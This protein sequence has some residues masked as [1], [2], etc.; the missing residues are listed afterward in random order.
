MNACS[1]TVSSRKLPA[2]SARKDPIRATSPPAEKAFPVPVKT[3]Q[4]APGSTQMDDAAP[5]SSFPISKSYTFIRSGRFI[6]I[7]ATPPCFS[8]I[9]VL[10]G[11]PSLSMGIAVA[12]SMP[13]RQCGS[14][15]DHPPRHAVDRIVKLRQFLDRGRNPGIPGPGCG[16]HHAASGDGGDK[17]GPDDLPLTD[18]RGRFPSCEKIMSQGVVVEAFGRRKLDQGRSD[19]DVGTGRSFGEGDPRKDLLPVQ[20]ERHGRSFE[21]IR[22]CVDEFPPGMIAGHRAQ[23]RRELSLPR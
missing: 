15:P 13:G 14:V 12:N 23:G 19:V 2:A 5:C 8:T 20:N 21:E 18:A 3:M 10:M 7:V 1:Q 4:R 22:S 16:V 17:A 9:T 6:R 11:S